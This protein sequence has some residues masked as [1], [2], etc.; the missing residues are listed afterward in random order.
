MII[1]FWQLV[2]ARIKVSQLNGI[3]TSFNDP[4]K[5]KIIEKPIDNENNKFHERL[6][7]EIISIQSKNLSFIQIYS[8]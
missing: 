4:R 2:I 7:H 1:P 6:R 5:W 3:L 8:S